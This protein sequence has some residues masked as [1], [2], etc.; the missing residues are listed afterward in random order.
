MQVYDSVPLQRPLRFCQV[1]RLTDQITLAGKAVKRKAIVM[2]TACTVKG[3]GDN[4]VAVSI[5]CK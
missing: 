2:G 1:I 5:D 4:E 3:P